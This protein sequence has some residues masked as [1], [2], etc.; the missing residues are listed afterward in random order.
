ME[1]I[2]HRHESLA[3][4]AVIAHQK[5]QLNKAER[6]Y[7][8]FLLAEPD[9][10]GALHLLGTLL[11]QRGDSAEALP[12]LNKAAQTTPQDAEIHNNLGVVLNTLGRPAEAAV[13][14][15]R[16]L[17]LDPL[18]AST[19]NNLGVAYRALRRLP[20]AVAC[21]EHSRALKH[22]AGTVNN[23]GLAYLDLERVENATRCFREAIALDPASAQA[24]LHLAFAL[25]KAG[26]LLGALESLDAAAN[27]DPGHGQVLAMRSHLRQILC[28][29]RAFATDRK[30][31]SLDVGPWRRRD[32]PS[33]FPVLALTDDPGVQLKRGR[34]YAAPLALPAPRASGPRHPGRIRLAYLSPDFRAHP[35]AALMVDVLALHD[36]E[37]FEIVALSYGPDDGS[38]LRARIAEA[39]DQFVDAHGWSD[40]EAA[41]FLRAWP[42]DIAVDLAGFTT[43]SRP[44]ILASRP[45][46]VQGN[47][48]GFPGPTGA[49]WIDFTVGDAFLA[50]EG[51]L[52]GG[53]SETIIAQPG[54]FQANS[55]RPP[56]S[57]LP[58][59]STEGLP[60][61]GFVF[62]SF[63][64]SYK[65][66]PTIFAI[67]MRLLQAIP[68]SVLWLLADNEPARGNLRREAGRHGVD[69]QRLVFAQRVSYEAYLARLPLADLFLDTF[70]FNA[71]TTASDALWMGL[72]LMTCSGRAYASR[73][74]GSLLTALG[75]PELVTDSL[76]AYERQALQLARDPATLEQVRARLDE[77]LR[78]GPAV[79]DPGIFTRRLEAAFEALV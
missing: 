41:G 74:A 78:S 3:R 30:M 40:A 66:V 56:R 54:C 71:G 57:A 48:L 18:S 67:W 35:V 17:E 19:H 26:D 21:F 34:D 32:P 60:E 50:N 22:D 59:R 62:C 7:R 39:A 14:L 55:R 1:R 33:P 63:S 58:A 31:L 8:A 9:H 53:F 13:A 27:L 28:D 4:D 23:L 70:P 10:P 64:N 65:I 52:Q 29:W 25:R 5:G 43:L 75:L 73:M 11:H 16:S 12:L 51:K 49:D 72:P 37:R 2:R 36:R 44:G 69:P 24:H 6:L 20:E 38:H 46:R 42:A 77:I 68:G 15:E 79:F 45:A 61:A 76:D 47:Y